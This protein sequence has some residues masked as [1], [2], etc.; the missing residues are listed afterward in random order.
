MK[1]TDLRSLSV[2]ELVR[3]VRELALRQS[4]AELYGRISKYNQLYRQIVAIKDE[5]KS[6][7][8]DQRRALESLFTDANPQVR[9]VAAQWSLAVLPGQA[10]EVLQQ[11]SDRNE[12]PQAADAR[13]SL[14]RIKSGQSVLL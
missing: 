4:Q 2:S 10:I 7:E 11:I 5:L 13:L 6:R 3:Q 9:L 14:E 12:Y 8:G 1:A